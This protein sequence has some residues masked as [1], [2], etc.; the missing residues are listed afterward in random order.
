MGINADKETT[1]DKLDA[2][3]FADT[4]K[5]TFIEVNCNDTADCEKAMNE[6]ILQII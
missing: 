6:A 1:F 4:N 5:M 3:K 2:Y